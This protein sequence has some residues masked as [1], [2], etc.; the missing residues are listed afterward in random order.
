MVLDGIREVRVKDWCD[1]DNL[2]QDSSW[3]DIYEQIKEKVNPDEK[4]LLDFKGINVIEPW[5]LDTFGKILKFNNIY[6]RFTSYN[7]ETLTNFVNRI[8]M[9]CVIEGLLVDRIDAV[10]IEPVKVKT[11]AEIKVEKGG[12]DIIKQF[13]ISEN[14]AVFN[15]AAYIDQMGSVDTVLSLSYAIKKISENYDIK[16]FIIITKRIFIQDNIIELLAKLILELDEDYGIELLIDTD[17]EATAKKLGL[18]VYTSSN[19]SYTIEKKIKAFA[20]LPLNMAG[21]L[22]K[23]KNSRAVDEFGR[24]G[25]GTVVSNRIAIFRGLCIK[26]GFNEVEIIKK[27]HTIEDK[28]VH[29][30]AIITTPRGKK[31]TTKWVDIDNL[32]VYIDSY[33]NDK[34][35][36]HAE[37]ETYHDGEMLDEKGNEI[38]EL[39]KTRI[40]EDINHVGLMNKFLGKRYHFL[41]PIQKSSA[42]N[43]KIITKIDDNGNCIR[44]EVTIPERIKI[45]L[46]DWGEKVSFELERDI[47]ESKKFHTNK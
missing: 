6:F 43:K 12:E 13:V 21:M 14:D 18:F 29:V 1:I 30:T 20:E 33:H 28:Q 2:T 19:E 27:V 9:K 7:K 23:Y 25:K 15:I 4:V 11:K 34:F 32:C 35:V 42:D 3:V 47:Y 38:T 24:S 26:I 44:E 40:I 45:V 31:E 22:V 39:P 41:R 16:K 36:T 17:I 37:W 8:K 46:D 10:Y 5:T